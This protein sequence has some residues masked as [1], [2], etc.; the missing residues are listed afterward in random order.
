MP[1]PLLQERVDL[2]R[3]VDS[4]T[5]K[6]DVMT[7]LKVMYEG[8]AQ[9]MVKAYLNNIELSDPPSYLCHGQVGHGQVG[10]GQV[11]QGQ[12]GRGQCRTM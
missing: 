1:P 5:G 8:H 6:L 2:Q 10:H 11:G 12:V 4:L 9:A 7:G 3:Q